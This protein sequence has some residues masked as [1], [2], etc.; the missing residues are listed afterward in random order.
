MTWETLIAGRS[1]AFDPEDGNPF[2]SRA[3]KDI[4]PEPE[5]PHGFTIMVAARQSFAPLVCA[6]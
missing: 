3:N 6:S 4:T 1:V 2:N 5:S